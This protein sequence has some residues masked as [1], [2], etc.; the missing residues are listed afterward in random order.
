MR[1][2]IIG[3]RGYPSTYGGFETFVRVFAPYA[4]SQGHDVVV[5]GRGI[6]GAEAVDGVQVVNVRGV[7]SKTASTITYGWNAFR[8]ARGQL[9][10]VALVLNAANGLFLHLLR[11]PSVVNPDG[12]EWRRAKWGKIARGAFLLGAIFVSQRATRVVVDS[13]AIGRY[14]R[15]AFGRDSDFVP[16]GAEIENRPDTRRL[17]AMGLQQRSY[18]LAVARLS[19][20]NNVEITLQAFSKVRSR[21]PLV[22]IGDANYRS[23]TVRQLKTAAAGDSRIRWLGRVDD[24][25][26]LADLWANATLYIH[27]HSVGGTNPALLQAMGYGAGPVAYRTPFNREVLGCD[28]RLYSSPAELAR[29]WESSIDDVEA[30]DTWRRQCQVR[31]KRHYVWQDVCDRYLEIL[32][33]AHRERL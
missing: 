5:Y 26:L 2:A 10:D 18:A 20:E 8:H 19:P 11:C 14:W 17:E 7:D 31:I 22:V 13:Q 33:A 3:S 27:G 12:L 1:I 23:V 25:E 29:L 24:Q 16:Y 9:F 28:T 32:G 15:A 4:L 6:E 21:Q 30:Q